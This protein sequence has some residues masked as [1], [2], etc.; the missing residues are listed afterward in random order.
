[1]DLMAQCQCGSLRAIASGEPDFIIACHC[2][3][4]QRRTGA[5]FGSGAY[6][7]KP[8]VRVEGQ[9]RLYTRE[10]QEGRKVRYHF[11]PDCGTSVYWDLDRR[12]NHY[13]IAVGAFA[14]PSVLYRK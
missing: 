5:I 2:F 3:D 6:Y 12:P 14:D 4:C 1:M 9:S 7:G 13:G 8:Q 10:G 11:C